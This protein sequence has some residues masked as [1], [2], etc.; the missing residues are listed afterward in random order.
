[1]NKRICCCTS[2]CLTNKCLQESYEEKIKELEAEIEE[3]KSALS[4]ILGLKKI[5]KDKPK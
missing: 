3:L 4:F 2:D 1:M 5:I